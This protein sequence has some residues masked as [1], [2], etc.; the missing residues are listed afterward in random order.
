RFP[1][2]FSARNGSPNRAN[3]PLGEAMPYQ[4]ITNGSTAYA[5]D[6]D[7]VDR[8]LLSHCK[9]MMLDAYSR[10][11]RLSES[12]WYDPTS[13]GLPE[14]EQLEVD[15]LLVRSKARA[16]YESD[17]AFLRKVAPSSVLHVAQG[18][19][20]AVAKTAALKEKQLGRM[21]QLHSDNMLRIAK[22]A[23]SF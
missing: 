11:V 7:L 16:K 10:V 22:S 4:F 1:G 21:K 9:A 13:W 2:L 5:I 14:I 12:K 18:M 6:W 15:W 3:S 8:L 23:D 19:Q 20:W 17:R